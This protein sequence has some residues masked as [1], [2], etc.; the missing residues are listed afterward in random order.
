MNEIFLK[1]SFVYA[2]QCILSKILLK[3]SIQYK[4]V[5]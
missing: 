5:Y 1:I 3:V 2:T 4:N